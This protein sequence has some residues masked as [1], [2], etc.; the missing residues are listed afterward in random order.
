MRM[1]PSDPNEAPSPQRLRL[2]DLPGRK[3]TRFRLEPDEAARA[4]LAARLDLL[5]LKK[6]RFEGT[7]TPKGRGDWTLSATLGATVTQPC[8]ATL[9]PVTTRIDEAVERIYSAHYAEPEGDEVEIPEDDRLEPLPETLDLAAVIAEALALAL[10]LYPRAAEPGAGDAIA[11]PPGAEPLTEESVR[12]FAG[13]K[14]L[15]DRL[16][17]GDG[18]EN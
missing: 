4:A 5:A 6:L 9:A 14:A 13:L 11:T 2:G 8:V 12:P 15:K 17:G 18:D 10:P 3:P 7:L 16:D 1:P